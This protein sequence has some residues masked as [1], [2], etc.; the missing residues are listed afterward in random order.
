[1]NINR[2]NILRYHI[3]NMERRD[4]YGVNSGEADA[5]EVLHSMGIGRIPNTRAIAQLRALYDDRVGAAGLQE[6]DNVE[7]G[8]LDDDLDA[9]WAAAVSTHPGVMEHLVTLET[10]VNNVWAAMVERHEEELRRRNALR[11]ATIASLL[12]GST[13]TTPALTPSGSGGGSGG[14]SGGRKRKYKRTKKR[15]KSRKR[16]RRKRRK[17]KRRRRTKKRRYY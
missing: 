4:R 9:D 1:M 16:R 17:T 8:H 12:T 6:L 3:D 11:A 2:L 14:T 10:A 7:F 13:G 15:R 5:Q